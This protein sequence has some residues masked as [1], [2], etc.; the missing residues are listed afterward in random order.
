M[1]A[2][3][4]LADVVLQWLRRQPPQRLASCKMKPLHVICALRTERAHIET[5]AVPKLTILYTMIIN[6]TH[7]GKDDD[8]D[9]DLLLLLMMVMT[10]TLVI[11][12]ST[13]ITTPSLQ[14][15]ASAIDTA[16]ATS[17]R[18]YWFEGCG[19]AQAHG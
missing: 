18:T 3:T 14:F 17:W 15:S 8:A 4:S 10:M 5:I 7:Y 13:A 6:G 11:A 1:P 16:I 9:A 19:A 2:I 12:T